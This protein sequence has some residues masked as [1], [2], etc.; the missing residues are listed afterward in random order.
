MGFINMTIDNLEEEHIC[1]A[2]A[3]KKHQC[4]VGVKKEWLNYDVFQ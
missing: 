3:D 1:C 2:I 4:G